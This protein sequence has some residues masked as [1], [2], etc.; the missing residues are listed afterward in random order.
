MSI[1]G[2]RTTPPFGDLYYNLFAGKYFGTLPYPLLEI[3]PGNEYYYYN[4]YAFEMMNNY[5]FVSDAYAGFNIEHTLGGG[6]FNFIPLIKQ[7]EFL[8]F[9]TSKCVVGA[10]SP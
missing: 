2:W 6:I 9:W 7:L 4:K 1:S 3:H 10:L 8:Q 5:E